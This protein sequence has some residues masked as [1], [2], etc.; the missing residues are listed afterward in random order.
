MVLVTPHASP[1][2]LAKNFLGDQL[3]GLEEGSFLIKD[4]RVHPFLALSCLKRVSL[5]DLL[6]FVPKD[7]IL[8]Y[9]EEAEEGANIS[10]VLDYLYS[11]GA[12]QVVIL[13]SLSGTLE[14]I[15]ALLKVLGDSQGHTVLQD[16][17]DYVAYYPE[18]V[19]VIARQG[20]GEFSL[21]GFPEADVSL[22][23]VSKPIR[24]VHLSFASTDSLTNSILERVAVLKVK[25]GGVLLA[26]SNKDE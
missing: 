7:K 6:S 19:H 1:E 25:N 5:E 4:A 12:K 24:N 2:I 13:D 11:K 18:G 14:H 3:I 8:R 26:L 17:N 21:F 22:E 10:K 15:H 16:D 23:H 9:E 20:Y